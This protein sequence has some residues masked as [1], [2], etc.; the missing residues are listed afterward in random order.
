MLSLF[1]VPWIALATPLAVQPA[2][3][4]CVQAAHLE[5]E[6][7]AGYDGVRVVTAA[8]PAG[9]AAV[10]DVA[11]GGRWTSL[12]ARAGGPSTVRTTVPA[13]GGRLIIAI[14]P[15]LDAPASAC[16][17]RVE[18]LLGGEVVAHVAP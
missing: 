4:S 18:L 16:V 5:V 7:P 12:T 2:A 6:A 9:A 1:V 11:G 8:G 15:S 10:V 17:E 13:V 3:P 14:A